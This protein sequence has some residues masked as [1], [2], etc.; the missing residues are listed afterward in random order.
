MPKTQKKQGTKVDTRHSLS[1]RIALLEAENEA[2]R[3]HIV[4]CHSVIIGASHIVEHCHID[5]VD[6][7]TGE[8]I[9]RQLKQLLPQS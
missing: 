4:V 9:K 8:V 3:Q 6:L 7:L 1:A 5:H 2:L